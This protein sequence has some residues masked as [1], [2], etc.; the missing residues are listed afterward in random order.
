MRADLQTWLACALRKLHAALEP[1][2]VHGTLADAL[3]E[4]GRAPRG[5]PPGHSSAKTWEDVEIA[6]AVSWLTPHI[7]K[8][9]AI[10]DVAAAL[11]Q[12]SRTVE[13]ACEG[14]QYSTDG[15]V[16]GLAER[17]LEQMR[18]FSDRR[19]CVY[20]NKLRDLLS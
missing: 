10:A 11:H 8:M 17:V 18:R 7:G 2:E 16:E 5:R 13:R 4:F 3:N 19:D 14:L 12:D 1:G 20:S 6:A 9:S 15:G